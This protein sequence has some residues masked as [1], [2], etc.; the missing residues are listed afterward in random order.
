MKEPEIRSLD[1]QTTRP[2]EPE[3]RPLPSIEQ[4]LHAFIVESKEW[5]RFKADNAEKE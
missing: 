2:V 5:I 3:K 4:E 1:P